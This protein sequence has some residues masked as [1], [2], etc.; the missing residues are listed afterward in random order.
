M[1]DGGEVARFSAT[2]DSAFIDCQWINTSN[3][4]PQSVIDVASGGGFF[5][6]AWNPGE[7][8]VGVRISNT[9]PVYLFSFYAEHY[10][11][12]AISLNNANGVLALTNQ[13]ETS[14]NYISINNSSNVYMAGLL[15]GNWNS[16][17]PNLI[18]VANSQVSLFGMSLN[19][20]S[21][22][23]VT[24]K[25]S[26][27]ANYG[28]V[29]NSGS[30][31]E[32]NGFVKGAPV[33]FQISSTAT[34]AFGG[35]ASVLPGAIVASNYDYGQ[36]GTTYHFPQS[37]TSTSTYRTDSGRFNLKP[38]TDKSTTNP[39]V[40]GWMQTGSYMTYSVNV[41]STQTYNISLRTESQTG[42]TF[43]IEVDGVNVTGSINVPVTGPWDTASSWVD[44]PAGRYT[45]SAGAHTVRLVSDRW[46]FDANVIKFA[47][48][49]RHS[50]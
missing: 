8:T 6:N 3:N 7:A 31:V 20:D 11:G 47:L 36:D 23:V 15:A 5:E 16:N 44:I 18:S 19:D 27:T 9:A 40:V 41:S 2:T 34:N 4:N 42:G 30:F 12:V 39:W 14:P 10:K 22:G 29:N 24:D 50:H 38:N 25:T 32:L 26:G 1:A 33:S 45:V 13:F 28:S 43:H 46:Y 35:M 48:L 49:G 37:G 21:Q 17:A